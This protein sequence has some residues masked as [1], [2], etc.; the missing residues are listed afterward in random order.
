MAIKSPELFEI[1]AGWRESTKCSCGSR[2]WKV[3]HPR[4]GNKQPLTIA[5]GGEAVGVYVYAGEAIRTTAHAPSKDSPG[6]GWNHFADCPDREKYR[7]LSVSSEKAAPLPGLGKRGLVI[8][9]QAIESLS[10]GLTTKEPGTAMALLEWAHTLRYGHHPSEG[11]CDPA[12]CDSEATHKDEAEER[13]HFRVVSNAELQTRIRTMWEACSADGREMVLQTHG[14]VTLAFRLGV[15]SETEVMTWRRALDTCPFREGDKDTH[16]CSQ[17]WCAY[18][19]DLAAATHA[20]PP[21]D[22]VLPEG[23]SL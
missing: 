7:A 21:D 9:A 6:L 5:T 3:P 1:P 18:C 16:P 2:L 8:V 11:R 12:T 23:F 4:T 13:R 20:E 15:F 17:A 22:L 10:V 14:A 19:G